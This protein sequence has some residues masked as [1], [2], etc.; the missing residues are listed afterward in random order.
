MNPGFPDAT[1]PSHD[2]RRA[3]AANLRTAAILASIAVVFFVGFIL[4]QWM[5]GP[6]V[7][8]GVMGAIVLAF[9]VFAIGRNLRR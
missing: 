9:L 4:T 5:G 6:I 1:P 8:A 2:A 3:R 7:G